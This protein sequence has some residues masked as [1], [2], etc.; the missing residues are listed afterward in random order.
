M[1]TD[2]LDL[3][4]HRFTTDEL[5]EREKLPRWREEFGRTIVKVD[6]EPLS[7]DLPFR[8][9]ATLQC[10][11]G[12]GVASCDGA[13]LRL[14]RTRALA[15]DGDD[16]IG[17][18]VNMGSAALAS[19]RSADV[20]LGEGDGVFVLTD[21]PGALS[22]ARHF[23]FVF[24]RAALVQ[25][26]DSI[27]D[28]V[29]RSIPRGDESLRLLLRYLRLVR[30]E[31][32]TTSPALQEVII[33]HIHDLAALAIGAN[34]DARERGKG[35]VAAARLAAA[36]DHIGKRF[37]DPALTLANVAHQQQISPRYLQELLEQSG[38]SFVARVNELRLKRAFSLLTRFPDRPVSAIAASVG[39][40]NVSHFNRLF[41]Q[42]FGDSPSGVRSRS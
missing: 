18:I 28:L 11:P 33:G 21:E 40:S 26:L 29:M 14:H 42:R 6:I 7:S 38:A 23:S 34:R 36:I 30:D 20:V 25:R 12:L 41:R 10:L 17:L 22:G 32:G 1:T 19:Q 31:V 4:P 3:K 9:E 8:A 35:A 5:P 37:A 2:N 13:A 15:A 27:D 39:F 16:S 24:P